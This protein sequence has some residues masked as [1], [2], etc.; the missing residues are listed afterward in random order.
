MDIPKS[1]EIFNENFHN[2]S[3]IIAERR[4][5][6][7]R[8]QANNRGL[9]EILRYLYIYITCT[10]YIHICLSARALHKT[11]HT[12]GKS[13]HIGPFGIALRSTTLRSRPL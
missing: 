6:T 8:S 7:E 13:Y 4:E 9:F 12:L 2:A 5:R 11:V 3:I 10:V 1:L